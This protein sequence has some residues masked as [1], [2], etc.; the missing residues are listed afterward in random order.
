MPTAAEAGL[1]G[2]EVSVWWGLV[3]PAATPRA[4]VAKLN[5]EANRALHDPA[6]AKKLEELGVVITPSTPEEFGRFI[7]TQTELWTRV[8]KAGN[9]RPD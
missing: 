3:A 1:P 8:I 2:F 4:I 5:D 6:T 9:I 7:G